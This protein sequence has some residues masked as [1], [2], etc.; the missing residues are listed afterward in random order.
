MNDVFQAEIAASLGWRWT[1]GTTSDAGQLRYAGP[2]A[3]GSQACQAEAVWHDEHALL[4]AGAARNLDLTALTRALFD[5]MLST[6]L[7]AVKAILIVNDPTSTGR[8][9]VGPAAQKGWSGPWA[10]T[11]NWL[12]VPPDGVLLLGG[13][14]AGWPVDASHCSLRLAASDGDVDYS[15]AILG[16][17]AGMFAESSS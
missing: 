17:L 16:T 15:V 3:T 4:L 2:L 6:V 9:F 14:Q 1:S 12:E 8:L 5:D 11:G 10:G 13:R 7:T